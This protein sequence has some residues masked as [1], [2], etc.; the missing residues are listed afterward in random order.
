M[1]SV[2]PNEKP[3]T[4][5]DAD[6]KRENMISTSQPAPK[7]KLREAIVICAIV[8]TQLVQVSHYAHSEKMKYLTDPKDDPIRSWDCWSESDRRG[9][10]SGKGCFGMDCCVISV[11]IA[12]GSTEQC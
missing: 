5:P 2:G 12:P 9:I 10:R 1:D 6:Q 11:C 4:A 3:N 7:S 8:S